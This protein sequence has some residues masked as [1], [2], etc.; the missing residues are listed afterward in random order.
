[1]SMFNKW[2]TFKR[3]SHLGARKKPF[4]ASECTSLVDAEKFRRDIIRDVNKKIAVIQNGELQCD[5]C[6]T[7]SAALGRQVSG[8]LMLRCPYIYVHA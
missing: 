3:E 1:M 8:A 7:R 4:L 6:N 2:T 5:T